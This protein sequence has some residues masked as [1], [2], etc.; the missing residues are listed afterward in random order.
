MSTSAAAPRHIGLA[1]RTS[2]WDVKVSPYLYISPF[3]LSFAVFGIFPIAFNVVVA[4]H[5]WH[6][7]LGQGDFV[8][9]DNFRWVLEQPAFRT[10]LQNTFSIFLISRTLTPNGAVWH[11]L[12]AMALLG[13][14]M[15][16]IWAPL[17]A[18]ATRNLPMQLAGAGSGSSSLRQS[19]WCCS[20]C[21]SPG[22]ISARCSRHKGWSP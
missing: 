22:S 20:T 16:G 18:T 11:I 2:K 13:I 12:A 21:P 19:P 4:M 17:A 6:R 5:S 8:G 10:S 14:G 1:R 15:A 9:L 3:F 7:R